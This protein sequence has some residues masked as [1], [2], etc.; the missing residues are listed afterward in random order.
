[1][2]ALLTPTV[3]ASMATIIGFNRGDEIKND[4]TEPNGTLAFKK[5]TV[6]G[7]VEQAQNGVTDP[8]IAAA[9]FPIIPLPSNNF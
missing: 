2:A 6:I 1:M 3:A 8:N 7:I 4:M 5:P 9:I